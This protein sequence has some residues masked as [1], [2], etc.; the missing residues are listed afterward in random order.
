[1]ASSMAAAT[2]D[3]SAGGDVQGSRA[4][5]AT[6]KATR[7]AAAMTCDLT[8]Q[9]SG[10]ANHRTIRGCEP[11]HDQGTIRS[12]PANQQDIHSLQEKIKIKAKRSI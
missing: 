12:R 1:V 9:R 5:A 8:N 7:G 10:A 3:L 4:R 11:S 2:C 6:C